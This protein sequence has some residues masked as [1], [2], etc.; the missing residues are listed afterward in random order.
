MNA[1]QTA[2][3]K[4]IKNGEEA[5]R[6]SYVSRLHDNAAAIS[7]EAIERLKDRK[8]FRRYLNTALVALI[9]AGVFGVFGYLCMT[10]FFR[11]ET[12]TVT[13]AS[14]YAPDALIARSGM[15]YLA[16]GGDHAASDL[17]SAGASYYAVA[18]SPEGLSFEETGRKGVRIVAMEKAGGELLLR[19]RGVRFMLGSD[20]HSA[21]ALDCAFDRFA[22]AEE[23]VGL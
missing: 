15:D 21:D 23:Y 5:P 17:L 19:S 20:A 22:A 7:R 10:F 3:K 18:G 9:L 14:M 16:F 12:V 6:R 1:G 11:I 13:G 4:R 8:R 2:G